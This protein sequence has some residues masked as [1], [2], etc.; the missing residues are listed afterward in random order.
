MQSRGSSRGVHLIYALLTWVKSAPHDTN[1]SLSAWEALGAPDAGSLAVQLP[2][3]A[4]PGLCCRLPF[5][6]HRYLRASPISRQGLQGPQAPAALQAA[7]TAPPAGPPGTSHRLPEPTTRTLRLSPDTVPPSSCTGSCAHSPSSDKIPLSPPTEQA[8]P[9]RTPWP[10]E[11]GRPDPP[12]TQC[13]LGLRSS[14]SLLRA[15]GG[16]LWGA[17]TDSGGPEISSE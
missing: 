17:A 14:R 4:A 5:P 1:P 9:T 10:A 12:C 16:H 6:K 13:P 2:R 3:S 15:A 7:P 8:A 11:V